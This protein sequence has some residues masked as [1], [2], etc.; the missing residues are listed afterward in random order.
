VGTGALA[1]PGRAQLGRFSQPEVQVL[2]DSKKFTTRLYSRDSLRP[3]KRYSGPA[4]VTEYSA[5]TVIPPRA[6][7]HLDEA[8]NLVII[9]N[10]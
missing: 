4:I 9:L 3:G 5:T 7:F 10:R 1:R 6:R 8:S 2:F